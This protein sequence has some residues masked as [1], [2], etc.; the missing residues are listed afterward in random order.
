MSC[1]SEDCAHQVHAHSALGYMHVHPSHVTVPPSTDLG[2][3]AAEVLHSLAPVPTM[4]SLLYS[5]SGVSSSFGSAA[6]ICVSASTRERIATS[7]V[8]A[9]F[10]FTCRVLRCTRERQSHH[11]SSLWH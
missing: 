6:L 11:M 2:A 8:S 10:F 1:S 3:R 4:R 5:S 7:H 9:H